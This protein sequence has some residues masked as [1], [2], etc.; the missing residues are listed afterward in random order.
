MREDN[1]NYPKLP[2]VKQNIPH[3]IYVRPQSMR[4]AKQLTLIFMHTEAFKV[5]RNPLKQTHFQRMRENFRIDV[6][7]DIII[8][9]NPFNSHRPPQR[10]YTCTLYLYC[11]VYDTY[12]MMWTH[13][14]NGEQNLS[15]M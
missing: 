14:T 5:I 7:N 8:V 3:L 15:T 9:P 4:Y 12:E 2:T 13:S 6:C 11:L 1:E 10:I